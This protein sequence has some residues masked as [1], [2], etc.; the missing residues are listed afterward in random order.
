LISR[1]GVTLPEIYLRDIINNSSQDISF[2]DLG[3]VPQELFRSLV[4]LARLAH[5]NEVA[6]SMEWVTFNMAPILKLETSIR[7][8]TSPSFSDNTFEDAKDGESY[9]SYQF[10]QDS[11]HCAEAWRCTLLIY[12]ERVFK[13]DRTDS[14]PQKIHRLARRIIDHVRC[15]R[16]SSLIQKQLLL[17]V[18]LAGSELTDPDAQELVRGYCAWWT[19]KSHYEMFQ[20]VGALLEHIWKRRSNTFWW[21]V[22]VDEKTKASSSP[23]NQIRY[24]FG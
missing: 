5:E 8:W 16:R 23:T 7:K 19:E 9:E 14:A 6:C 24:L 13:W 3:G 21:G 12:I 20:T 18:F 1:E 17:P 15:C 4:Q 2:Y 10:M 11:Y 22:A